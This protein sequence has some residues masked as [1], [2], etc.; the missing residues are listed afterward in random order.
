M[1][2][3]ILRKLVGVGL[4]LCIFG[5]SMASVAATTAEISDYSEIAPFF[6]YDPKDDR[7]D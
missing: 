1:M 7:D 6:I 2:K 3:R 5:S 4:A